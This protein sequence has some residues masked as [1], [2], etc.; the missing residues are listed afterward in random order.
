MKEIL[1]LTPA[2]I[3]QIKEAL[4]KQS[5]DIQG[6]RV[7]IDGIMGKD[8]KV[9]LGF[10]KEV[11]S[12]DP[13]TSDPVTRDH[14]ISLKEFKVFIDAASL[15]NLKGTT[16]DF[17]DGPKGKGFKVDNPNRPDLGI[18][19][20][21]EGLLKDPYAK[22]I[23]DAIEQDVNPFVAQHGGFISLLDVKDQ[24]VYIY[25]GGGCQGCAQSQMTLKLGVE[26]MLKE[27]FPDIKGIVD[28]TDHDAGENPYYKE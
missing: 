4:S 23:Y 7:M 1:T 2:A 25:M 13:V 16:I 5:K 12:D 8:F 11:K 17:V 28:T 18:P 19:Q 10:E 9:K 27:K 15:E 14:V 20:P 24:K 21:R 26:K 3:E 22:K 6:I